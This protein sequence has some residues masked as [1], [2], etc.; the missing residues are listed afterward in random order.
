MPSLKVGSPILVKINNQVRMEM[1]A[2]S[3][4]PRVVMNSRQVES[5][6][7]TLASREV[8]FLSEA[9]RICWIERK[10]RKRE[11]KLA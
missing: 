5:A 7:Q 8:I 1:E 9:A 3:V 6:L 2:D 4:I 10:E 11:R